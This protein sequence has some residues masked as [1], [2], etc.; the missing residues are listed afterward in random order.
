MSIKLRKNERKPVKNEQGETPTVVGFGLGWD[1][2]DGPIDLDAA[3]LAF[4][5]GGNCLDKVN[6]QINMSKLRNQP[7]FYSG[8]NTTGKDLPVDSGGDDERIFAYL[9]DLPANVES[10]FILV[11]SYSGQAFNRIANANIRMIDFSEVARTES[12][13]RYSGNLLKCLAY[14]GQELYTYSLTDIKGDYTAL[15]LGRMYRQGDE[16]RFQALG[17][18]DYGRTAGDLIDSIKQ[19][20]F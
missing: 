13:K 11:T 7:V 14:K 18:T 6:F 9:R 10:L 1:G 3:A 4:D 16:F 2:D 20:Y 15:I 8:D 12:M 19:S 5:A 17:Q